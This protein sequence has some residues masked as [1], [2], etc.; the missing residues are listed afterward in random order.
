MYGLKLDMCS[1]NR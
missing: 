1:K